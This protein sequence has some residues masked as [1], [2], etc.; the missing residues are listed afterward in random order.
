MWIDEKQ[1]LKQAETVYYTIDLALER[2]QQ[3]QDS[4]ETIKYYTLQ[5][6]MN[7]LTDHKWHF[8]ERKFF[9][10]LRNK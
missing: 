6:I 7:I 2:K 9:N 4:D 10:N 8:F 1:A 3:G 5:T